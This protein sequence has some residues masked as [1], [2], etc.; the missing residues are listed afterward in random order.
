MKGRIIL[1][2]GITAIPSVF[3]FTP[4]AIAGAG[5]G[6]IGVL[7]GIAYLIARRS[8]KSRKLSADT[9]RMD[10]HGRRSRHLS[11]AAA[12][13]AQTAA[14][15]PRQASSL[16]TTLQAQIT[17]FNQMAAL[18]DRMYHEANNVLADKESSVEK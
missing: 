7:V 2:M 6:G 16:A 4:L 13:A 8:T 14:V 11:H 10:D 5:A 1:Y 3:A 12:K 18:F 17:Q 15:D 9:S